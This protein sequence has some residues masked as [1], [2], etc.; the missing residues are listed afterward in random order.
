MLTIMC[1]IYHVETDVL[2]ALSTRCM[3]FIVLYALT[4]CVLLDII[5]DKL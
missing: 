5:V 2:K 4:R 3:Q 1:R